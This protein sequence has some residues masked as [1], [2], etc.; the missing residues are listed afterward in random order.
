MNDNGKVVLGNTNPILEAT[1]DSFTITAKTVNSRV[2]LWR[3]W[4]HTY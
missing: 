3:Q 4:G 1:G 2:R